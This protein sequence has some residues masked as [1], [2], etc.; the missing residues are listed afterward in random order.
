MNLNGKWEEKLKI[1]LI[2][3]SICD[4]LRIIKIRKCFKLFLLKIR[5]ND[6]PWMVLNNT[7]NNKSPILMTFA[8]DSK[9]K[10]LEGCKRMNYLKH[11]NEL[12][13]EDFLGEWRNQDRTWS[14]ISDV[15]HEKLF[16][17]AFEISRKSWKSSE[18]VNLTFWTVII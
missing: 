8:S 4:Q 6:H 7:I 2:S 3:S 17:K 13:L 12:L 11:L 1:K 10:W 14:F 16:E 18:T 5:S 15:G 9:E